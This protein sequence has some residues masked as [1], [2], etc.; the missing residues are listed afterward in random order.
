MILHKNILTTP[1]NYE[2][3]HS[4]IRFILLLLHLSSNSLSNFMIY[5]YNN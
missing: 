2:P 3:P 4:V 5:G 1:E